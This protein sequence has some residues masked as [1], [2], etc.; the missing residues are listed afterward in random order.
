MI[1]ALPEAVLAD[2]DVLDFGDVTFEVIEV[3]NAN[4]PTNT[5]L[6]AAD[7][8]VLF[9]VEV[10]EDGVT[11]FLKDADLNGWIGV[12]W[13]LEDRLPELETVYGAHNAPAPADFAIAQQLA[14]LTAY[15]EALETALADGE[16]SN[17]ESTEATA[18]IEAAFPD[19]ARVARL[20]RADLIGL[21]LDWQ[22]E[23]R[24]SN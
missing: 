15:R 23:T 19:H 14:H 1:A 4:A 2:G 13:E 20:E 22:A 11:V 7:E 16:M 5:L 18:R 3:P 10:V 17:D 6:H 21:N 8:G 9:S 12:L 24:R